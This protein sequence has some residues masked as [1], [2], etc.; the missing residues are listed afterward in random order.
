MSPE[1]ERTPVL[2]HSCQ[3]GARWGGAN[4]AHCA[5]D[6]H[7]TFTAVGPFD[8]HRRGGVCLE[9]EAV[10]L[11]LAAGRPYECWGGGTPEGKI[12]T[13]IR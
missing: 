1:A 6:C 11:Q 12:F 3:C 10:G 13:P 5:A 7:R 8:L 2:A 9:P 4:T